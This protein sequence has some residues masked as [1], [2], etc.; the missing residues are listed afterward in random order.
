M[1]CPGMSCHVASALMM[2]LIGQVGSNTRP[3]RLVLS[4]GSIVPFNVPTPCSFAV[5]E[6]HFPRIMHRIM[7]TSMNSP[8]KHPSRK[9]AQSTTNPNQLFKSQ[10]FPCPP[11]RQRVKHPTKI[12]SPRKI[13]QKSQYPITIINHPPKYRLEASTA[14]PSA[15]AQHRPTS[16]P[17]PSTR[18]LH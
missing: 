13:N 16:R 11:S 18:K 4:V 17:I 7:H 9:S 8:L 15:I 2:V 12:K 1:G 6:G 5:H 10:T 14:P 3:R